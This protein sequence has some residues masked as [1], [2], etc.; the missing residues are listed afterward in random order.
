MAVLMLKLSNHGDSLQ[1]LRHVETETIT[2]TMMYSDT[3]YSFL[4]NQL[5]YYQLQLLIYYQEYNQEHA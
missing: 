1:Q 3:F 5:I 2:I 4:C